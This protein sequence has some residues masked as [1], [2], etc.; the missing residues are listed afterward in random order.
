M[1]S[2]VSSLSGTG[3]DK[4]HQ[5][6]KFWKRK[7]IFFCLNRIRW[8][9]Y[10]YLLKKTIIDIYIKNAP[11]SFLLLNGRKISNFLWHVYD[12]THWGC[13]E[14]KNNQQEFEN[15]ITDFV[16]VNEVNNAECFRILY[17]CWIRRNNELWEMMYNN[18]RYFVKM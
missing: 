14:E 13:S 15:V 4:I 12:E 6:I 5:N 17:F 9:F 11:F 3:L 18:I 2:S 16:L 8:N 1:R 10:D 7:K